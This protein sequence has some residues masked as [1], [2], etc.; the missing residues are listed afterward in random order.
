MK[1]FRKNTQIK[2]ENNTKSITTINAKI[3]DLQN[4]ISQKQDL[5]T[6]QDKITKK[7][8]YGNLIASREEILSLTNIRFNPKDWSKYPAIDKDHLPYFPEVIC[9]T[10][11]DLIKKYFIHFI[12][13]DGANYIIYLKGSTFYTE[14]LNS[15][16]LEVIY[17]RNPQHSDT[18]DNILDLVAGIKITKTLYENSQMSYNP[19]AEGV[20]STVDLSDS[21]G[22]KKL[23]YVETDSDNFVGYLPI[24]VK[25]DLKSY[26]GTDIITGEKASFVDFVYEWYKTQEQS[27]PV[28]DIHVQYRIFD[29]PSNYMQK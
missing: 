15:Y 21:R 12:G 26:T 10:L 20:F 9:P 4:Q 13:T 23:P 14:E 1:L 6:Q 3:Q 5:I 17:S 27:L 19:M 16:F 18:Q 2:T 29:Y 7:I 25:A 22:Y 8:I 24:K 11:E 28:N